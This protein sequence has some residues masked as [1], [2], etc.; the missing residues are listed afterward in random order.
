MPQGSNP[1]SHFNKP[2]VG[3]TIKKV[4]MHTK[5]WKLAKVL[6]AGNLN[7]GMREAMR[8]IEILSQKYITQASEILECDRDPEAI[9]AKLTKLFPD[10]NSGRKS[11]ADITAEI[12]LGEC[13]LVKEKDG[14]YRVVKTV[15]VE[16]PSPLNDGTWLWEDRIEKKDSVIQREFKGIAEKFQG[17][18]KPIEAAMR[19]VKEEIQLSTSEQQYTYLGQFFEDNPKSAYKGISSKV[20]LYKFRCYIY[21]DDYRDE[22]REISDGQVTVFCWR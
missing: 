12:C 18:E 17:D 19:G 16:I 20:D 21:A 4:Q 10:I 9:T 7:Q 3:G 15:L 1:R 8:S 6:G 5:Y 14:I 2:K 22:Y 11:A 13:S